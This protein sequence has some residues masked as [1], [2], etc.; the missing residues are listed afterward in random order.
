M[1]E[2]E[3]RK[4]LESEVY[5]L[6]KK[7]VQ[8]KIQVVQ[9]SHSYVDVYGVQTFVEKRQTYWQFKRYQFGRIDDQTFGSIPNFWDVPIS[10]CDDKVKLFKNHVEH[11]YVKHSE[12][13]QSN[14]RK[15][16]LKSIL[17]LLIFRFL[18]KS[19][20]DCSNCNFDDT[21]LTQSNSISC[22]YCGGFKKLIHYLNCKISWHNYKDE[23]V[24]SKESHLIPFDKLKQAPGELIYEFEDKKINAINYSESEE[25]SEASVKFLNLHRKKSKNY[26]II[27]QV[28]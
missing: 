5:F 14:C 19:P 15:K 13:I 22:T 1:T 21:R 11:V 6:K 12:Y 16:H 7:N 4:I 8:D 26:K 23:L 24:S 2:K 28:N 25:I 27:K 10:N 9:M 3:V 18:L 20:L 17:I